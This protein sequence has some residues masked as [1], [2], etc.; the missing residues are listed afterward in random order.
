M[1]LLQQV[2]AAWGQAGLNI[3]VIAEKPARVQAL[4]DRSR[5]DQAFTLA[6]RTLDQAG[7]RTCAER[8]S[9]LWSIFAFS[10]IESICIELGDGL[11]RR[12]R[13]LGRRALRI[14]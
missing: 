6:V 2:E 3:P 14:A 4:V 13:F 11:I 1:T 7:C 5:R 10:E 8:D 12:R 9:N